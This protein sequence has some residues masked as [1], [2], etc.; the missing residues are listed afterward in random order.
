MDD[1]LGSP[2]TLE[3]IRIAIAIEK[4]PEKIP[5]WGPNAGRSRSVRISAAP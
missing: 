5:P 2:M 4:K 3:T 1:E